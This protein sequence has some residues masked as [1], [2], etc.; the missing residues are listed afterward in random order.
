MVLV[1]GKGGGGRAPGGDGEEEAQEKEDGG[2]RHCGFLK[3]YRSKG[4]YSLLVGT[5]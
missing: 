2:A 3:S 1:T 5:A 4:M